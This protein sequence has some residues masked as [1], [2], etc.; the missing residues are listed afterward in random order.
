M[1]PDQLLPPGPLV[2]DVDGLTLNAEDRE[3]IAHPL[4]GGVVLFARNYQSKEQLSELTRQ[5]RESRHGHV[6]IAVDQ[7]G[8]RVQRFRDGFSP[9]PP[10]R[11]FGECY[12]Q[13]PRTAVKQLTEVATLLAWELRQCDIDFSFAPVAD[14][15]RDLCPAIGSRALHRTAEGVFAL[16]TAVMNGFAA[17]GCSNVV[18]HFPGHGSVDVD[19]HT[20]F[21][22]DHRSF[23][24]IQQSD[25]QPFM[26]LKDQATAVMPAHV[27]FDQ[28]DD[29]PASL[30][31]VWQGE[32]LRKQLRFTGAI[33]S[34]DLSMSAISKAMPQADAA[35]MAIT[36]G[37]DLVLICNDRQAA[38][39]AFD[40]PG[41]VVGT[42]T[43]FTRRLSMAA[44]RV[45]SP[46]ESLVASARQT[47]EAV[48]V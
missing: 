46:A 15:D 5:I 34:D 40:H 38:A 44:R 30:S 3:L 39:A 43:Q 42:E 45:A 27:V 16:A 6:L 36:A 7:E 1:K 14:L 41:I 13:N 4:T 17:A 12:D 20:D 19:T 9:I 24:E 28:V 32:I 23:A 25:M 48:I 47:I 29:Q 8:G 21:A 10:M 22:H 18:K 35:A 11:L 33:I 2:I 31:A 26:L 37:S